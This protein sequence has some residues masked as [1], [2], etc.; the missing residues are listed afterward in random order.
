MK[1]RIPSSKHIRLMGVVFM[2]SLGILAL[3]PVSCAPAQV[4]PQNVLT[5]ETKN[6]GPVVFHAE[7]AVSPEEQEKGLMDRKFLAPDSGMLFVFHGE[8]QRAFWMKN[9]LIP[10]DM[11]FIS[12]NGRINHIH[13]MAKP[14]DETRIT[15][16]EPAMAVFEINGGLADQ[17]GIQEGDIVIH[18]VFRNQLAD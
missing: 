3:I 13:H 2:L 4:D 5:I 11:L 14:L 8:E 9:T 12:Q 16:D 1:H 7:L 17:L 10:L 15:S 6:Q 18:P